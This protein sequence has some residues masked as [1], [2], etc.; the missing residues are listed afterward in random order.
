LSAP[1]GVVSLSFIQ[2]RTMTIR[3]ARAVNWQASGFHGAVE[4]D[5]SK[6]CGQLK[7]TASND[8]LRKLLP[9]F[10]FT[11]LGDGLRDTCAWFHDNYAVA[12]K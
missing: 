10:K 1:V 2:R 12:R 3:S 6:A 11:A 5:V 7:K 9:D 4:M 8:K